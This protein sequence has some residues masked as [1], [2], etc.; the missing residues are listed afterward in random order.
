MKRDLKTSDFPVMSW[1]DL[2]VVE[3][4]G[5]LVPL[6][7]LEDPEAPSGS[8]GWS[9]KQKGRQNQIEGK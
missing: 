7:E 4:A 2:L 1:T 3:V 6:E 5:T 8:E 9:R